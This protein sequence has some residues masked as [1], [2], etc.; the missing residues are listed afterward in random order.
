MAPLRLDSPPPK[1][2]PT[3]V[4]GN[5][6]TSPYELMRSAVVRRADVP[7][8]IHADCGRNVAATLARQTSHHRTTPTRWFWPDTGALNHAGCVSPA[9]LHSEHRPR[10]PNCTAISNIRSVQSWEHPHTPLG[11]QASSWS[12]V[13][14]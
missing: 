9:I 3:H 12:G 6:R 7:R 11:T 10:Q 1:S 14:S 5:P 13:R 4:M 2:Q 8:R